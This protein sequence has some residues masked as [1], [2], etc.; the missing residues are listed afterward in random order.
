MRRLASHAV[1]ETR[2]VVF[3]VVG[4]VEGRPCA[5]CGRDGDAHRTAAVLADGVVATPPRR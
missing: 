3:A 5:S 1:G 2:D 4:F